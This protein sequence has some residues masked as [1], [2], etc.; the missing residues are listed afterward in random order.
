MYVYA[1]CAKMLRILSI[2]FAQTIAPYI[3]QKYTFVFKIKNKF[4][5]LIILE[6]DF[7][8]KD[9]HVGTS[10]LLRMTWREGLLRLWRA[11]G[12]GVRA[13]H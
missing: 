1:K 11:W 5:F 3:L 4:D 9:S 6:W 10:S 2:S 13:S 8:L 7:V 12:Y